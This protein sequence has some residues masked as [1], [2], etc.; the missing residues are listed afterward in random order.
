ML[1]GTPSA[2]SRDLRSRAEAAGVGG[3]PASGGGSSVTVKVKRSARNPVD[4]SQ[5]QAEKMP[6]AAVLPPF[7][8][9]AAE[10]PLQE[11][12]T[13][14]GRENGRTGRA[15]RGCV[16][17]CLFPAPYTALPIRSGRLTRRYQART[18]IMAWQ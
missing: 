15:G 4:T 6:Y 7:L 9:T 3:S 10:V 16:L 13:A 1:Q 12:Q 2:G 11:H 18:R 14:A 8:I 17:Y 5:V